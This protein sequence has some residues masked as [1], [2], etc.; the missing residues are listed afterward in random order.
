MNRVVLLLFKYSNQPDFRHKMPE[1]LSLLGTLMEKETG[2]EYLE[3]VL[4][5]LSSVVDEDELSLEQIKEMAKKAISKDA[6]GYVM[7]LAE[8]WHNEG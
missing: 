5:Y 1:I 2:L 8:R 6:G 7:T 3:T 4:R